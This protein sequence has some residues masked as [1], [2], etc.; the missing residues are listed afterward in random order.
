MRSVRL[1]PFSAKL[2]AIR[3]NSVCQARPPSVP[4]E[5]TNAS[6]DAGDA[7]PVPYAPS[8]SAPD[9]CS[10]MEASVSAVSALTESVALS[11]IDRAVAPTDCHTC[12]KHDVPEGVYTMAELTEELRQLKA[13]VA[14]LEQAT[15][16]HFVRV[17]QDMKDGG[18]K[19]D[20]RSLGGGGG[21]DDD[22]LEAREAG[23]M[24]LGP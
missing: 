17:E 3:T 22:T 13:R 14:H 4:K 21:D 2:L 11:V 7:P 23:P 10:R 6:A 19:L 24:S 20:F 8:R 12:G 16:A 5:T 18:A 1:D 15:D 9:A